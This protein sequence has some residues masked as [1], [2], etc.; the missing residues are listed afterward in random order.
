MWRVRWRFALLRIAVWAAPR[1]GEE[2][3]GERRRGAGALALTV[4]LGSFAGPYFCREMH[5]FHR[6]PL[7]DRRETLRCAVSACLARFKPIV[8]V[9]HSAKERRQFPERRLGPISGRPTTKAQSELSS[10]WPLP[11][12]AS[13][14]SGAIESLCKKGL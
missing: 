14:S 11:K 1:F 7:R 13:H 8:R 2:R 3:L 12:H 5:C 9:A 6:A 10:Y 4:D